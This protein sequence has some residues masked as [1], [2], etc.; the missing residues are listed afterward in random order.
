MPDDGIVDRLAGGLLP[1]DGGLALVGDAHRG[2]VFGID[3]GL[4][5]SAGNDFLDAFPDFHGIVLDPAGLGI[6]LLVFFLIDADDLA[7]MI[8]DHKA[9][10]GRALIDCCCILWH[11]CLLSET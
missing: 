7:G 3:V 11:R 5:E 4:F 1:D 2:D 8:E 10:A 6:D 9:G